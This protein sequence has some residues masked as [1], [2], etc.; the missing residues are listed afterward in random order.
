MSDYT[1]PSERLTEL[2][3]GTY[4]GVRGG[5]PTNYSTVVPTAL[6]DITANVAAAASYSTIQLA[7]GRVVGGF[8]GKSLVKVKG[9]SPDLRDVNS[10]DVTILEAD[11]SLGFY[12]GSNSD[13]GINY[14]ASGNL[15]TTKTHAAGDD[16][17]TIADTSDFSAG[18][19]IIL[20]IQ[21]Q[22]DNTAISAGA[23]V[24]Y[25]VRPLDDYVRKFSAVVIS[26]T[27]ST[28]TFFPPLPCECT[29]LDIK[30]NLMRSKMSGFGLEDVIIDCSNAAVQWAVWF[31]QCVDC[32][33]DNVRVINATNY[34][35]FQSN[36][37]F[38]EFRRCFADQ[39][40]PGGSNGA[41]FLINTTGSFL[42]EDSVSYK[43]NPGIEV[44]AGSSRGAVGYNLFE[45]PRPT[46]GINSNHN[47]HNS[48]VA[49][50]GN[51]TSTNQ[52]DGYYGSASRDTFWRN[53]LTG[54]IYD[55]TT[56]TSIVS[57]NRFTR[58]Y[59]M[60]GNL[61]GVPTWPYGDNPFSF[62]NPNL[63]NSSYDGTAEPSTGDF[64][65][66]WKGTG[67]L[68]TR[69]DATHGV[70]TLDGNYDLVTNQ[71]A[72]F[73]SNSDGTNL[74]IL[75]D[76]VRSGSTISF[77]FGGTLPTAGS[78]VR[79]YTGETGFQ[80]SDLDVE[81]TTILKGNYLFWGTGGTYGPGVPSSQSLS[82]QTLAASIYR[83]SKPAFLGSAPWPVF[84]PDATFDATSVGA[85]Y[86]RLPAARRFLGL[87]DAPAPPTTPQP[88]RRSAS[89][90]GFNQL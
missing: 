70:I 6:T 17:V 90:F 76:V 59:S 21:N 10:P 39:R 86:D 18:L 79:V 57:L 63:G 9:N 36:S 69:T 67:T 40:R 62:G 7:A 48:F 2:T 88:R 13:Y 46:A 65:R 4:T 37:I 1:L 77:T 54:C 81:S 35:F 11:G 64:W 58:K 71:F 29:G 30:V 89:L 45:D 12:A 61:L 42:I 50:E 19:A 5:I 75:T 34:A 87:D 55:R 14:P 26:K 66:D 23:D 16:T 53:Y 74:G 15:D 82:G 72:S 83:T 41:G 84:G 56:Y 24:V 31:E 60:V 51:I 33:V 47:P 32:W 73:V 52:A 3:P 85:G 27:S 28:V 80:E 44:N 38:C 49:Y 22:Q 25:Q 68:T 43:F 20:G 78:A 8:G